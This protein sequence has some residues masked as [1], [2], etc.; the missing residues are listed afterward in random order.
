MSEL[1]ITL[2]NFAIIYRYLI[3][4]VFASSSYFSSTFLGSSEEYHELFDL[5]PYGVIL[6]AFHSKAKE[7]GLYEYQRAWMINKRLREISIAHEKTSLA[8]TVADFIDIVTELKN[9]QS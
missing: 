8:R 5:T 2:S 3:L 6:S 9:R 4:K 7:I 1:F